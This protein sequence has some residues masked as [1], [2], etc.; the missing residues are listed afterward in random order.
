MSKFLHP[1]LLPR[2]LKFSGRPRSSWYPWSSLNLFLFCH[3]S[4]W[5]PHPRISICDHF[6]CVSLKNKNSHRRFSRNLMNYS[7]SL[8]IL[9]FWFCVTPYKMVLTFKSVD[10]HLMWDHSNGSYWAVLF[11]MLFKV[12]LPFTS[13]NE[14][15][16]CDHW[17]WSYW[18][19]LSCST[20]YFAVQRCF[21]F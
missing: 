1:F 12:I 15:L 14:T 4:A 13:V 6:S 16:I 5:K 9:S 10:A 11:I 19:I 7:Y 3:V 17:N 20:V 8:G 2:L 21:N 18:V